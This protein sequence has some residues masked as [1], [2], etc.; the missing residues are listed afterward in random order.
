[1]K[2]HINKDSGLTNEFINHDFSLPD[3]EYAQ[4]PVIGHGLE[5]LAFVMFEAAR[6]KDA[7]FFRHSFN[8]VQET[9]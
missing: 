7:E 8:R 9:C 3:N 4:F 1:M 6:C 5:T 2:Y